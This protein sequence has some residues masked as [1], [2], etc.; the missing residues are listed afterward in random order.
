MISG[1]IVRVRCTNCGRVFDVHPVE[2]DM[3][4]CYCGCGV[5]V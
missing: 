3:L 4:V 1:E 2:L 5:F